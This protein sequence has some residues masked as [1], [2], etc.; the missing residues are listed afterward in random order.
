M[1][2]RYL[3]IAAVAAAALVF[4][5]EDQTAYACPMCKA[6]TE[7]EDHRP[8][9]YMYSILF[10]LFVPATIFSGLGFGLYKMARRENDILADSEYAGDED[11]PTA[12]R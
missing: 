8:Q 5:P 4:S 1:F 3:A 2:R 12:L 6:S 10:M 9:A 7:N 11:D